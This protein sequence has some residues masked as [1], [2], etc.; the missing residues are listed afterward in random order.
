LIISLMFRTGTGWYVVY[1]RTLSVNNCFLHLC[2]NILVY[3]NENK[4][5]YKPLVRYLFF[6]PTSNLIIF[7]YNDPNP[8]LP[9]VCVCLTNF[10][11]GRW[12][13]LYKNGGPLLNRKGLI[14]R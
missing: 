12:L 4:L 5:G 14:N 11:T 9:P 8:M 10:N 3:I 7:I 1:F 6:Y 2:Q 13:K